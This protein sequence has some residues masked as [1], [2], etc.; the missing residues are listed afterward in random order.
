LSYLNVGADLVAAV[1][2]TIGL[3]YTILIWRLVRA[4]S[5]AMLVAAMTYQLVVRLW[6]TV[7][8][9]DNKLGWVEI[10]RSILILPSY[11]LLALAF[12]MTYYELRD[13][14]FDVP[15]DAEDRDTEAKH[16]QRM[17]RQSKPMRG[18]KDD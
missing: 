8:E 6:L 17:K 14:R 15:K 9:T 13:F 1:F 5:R 10:H 3:V 11:V 16:I 7:L 4:H 12:G 2:I 18:A